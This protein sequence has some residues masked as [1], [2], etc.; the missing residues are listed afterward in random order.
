MAQTPDRGALN[1]T[2]QPVFE[3]DASQK[4]SLSAQSLDGELTQLLE[5]YAASHPEA[6]RQALETAS[7]DVKQVLLRALAISVTGYQDA[8]DA[9][10]R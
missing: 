7:A 8:L 10:E 4:E 6:I 1:A 9:I 3:A 5:Y 2:D